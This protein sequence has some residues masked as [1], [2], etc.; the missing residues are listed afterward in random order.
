MGAEIWIVELER[1]ALVSEQRTAPLETALLIRFDA[2]QDPLQD[3]F[4]VTRTQTQEAGRLRCP[5]LDC[6]KWRPVLVL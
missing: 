6:G 2:S 5:A 1:L 4:L 3:L